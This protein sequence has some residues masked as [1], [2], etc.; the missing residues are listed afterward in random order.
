MPIGTGA[1]YN[2]FTGPFGDWAK[3]ADIW[4]ESAQYSLAIYKATASDPLRNVTMYHLSEYN[5]VADPNNPNFC[6]SIIQKGATYQIRIPNHAVPPPPTH[7]VPGTSDALL[8]IVDPDGEHVW[9]LNGSQ[10]LADG[11]WRAHQLIKNQLKT[12]GW[13][14]YKCKHSASASGAYLLG[15]AIRVGELQNGIKH[16]LRAVIG[17]NI[18]NKNGPGGKSWVWPATLSDGPQ[19]YATTGNVFIGSLLAIPASVDLDALTWATVEGKNVAKAMQQYGIYDVDSTTFG[20]KVVIKGDLS[21]SG[22][23]P[24]GAAGQPFLDD[25]IQARNFLK[26]VSNNGPNSIGGGGTPC[27]PLAPPF[28][29][30]GGRW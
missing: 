15:G 5:S 1:V 26:V 30:P 25:L 28:T 21:M 29:R 23:V 16:A 11:N 3:N 7:G 17:G 9:E 20:P 8:A 14:G 22:E 24:A 2:T 6:N 12:D 19:S 4:L 13:S 18:P 10:K 27:C